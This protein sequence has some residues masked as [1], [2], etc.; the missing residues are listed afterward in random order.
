MA[1]SY[2]S[3]ELGARQLPP[4]IVPG[5]GSSVGLDPR[6][7]TGRRR[8]E[9]FNLWAGNDSDERAANNMGRNG[10]RMYVP[11]AHY[12]DRYI[13]AQYRILVC[14]LRWAMLHGPHLCSGPIRSETVGRPSP[15]PLPPPPRSSADA[16]GRLAVAEA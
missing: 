16:G 10:I 3:P 2:R 12:M 1:L 15:W 14:A 6:K 7:K 11:L 5:T 8:P 13:R 4:L 9:L